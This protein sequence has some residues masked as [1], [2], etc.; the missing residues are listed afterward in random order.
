MVQSRASLTGGYRQP[1]VKG[2]WLGGLATPRPQ[3]SE[4]SGIYGGPPSGFGPASRRIWSRAVLVL[5]SLP[6]TPFV[7]S[8]MLHSPSRMDRGSAWR[9]G[10]TPTALLAAG[11]GS[12]GLLGGPNPHS[13]H[14]QEACAGVCVCV[15]EVMPDS[16][17]HISFLDL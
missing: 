1:R 11:G 8:S 6:P 16:L 2:W 10:A 3:G 7:V 12:R 14:L 17:E 4:I 9:P 13:K 15:P 5:C